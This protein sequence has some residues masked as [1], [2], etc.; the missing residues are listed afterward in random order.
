MDQL[1][2]ET[3]KIIIDEE[4]NEY[5]IPERKILTAYQ[6]HLKKLEIITLGIYPIETTREIVLSHR[7]LKEIPHFISFYKK[8]ETLIIINNE[9][10]ELNIDHLPV[11]LKSI[12]ISSNKIKHIPP[13]ISLLRNLSI[14][15]CNDNFVYGKVEHLPPSLTIL[16]LSKNRINEINCNL[17]NLEVLDCRYNL[18]GELPKINVNKIRILRCS[19]NMIHTLPLKMSKITQLVVYDNLIQSIPNYSS[20]HISNYNIKIGDNPLYQICDIQTCDTTI[21]NMEVFMNSICNEISLPNIYK[22]PGWRIMNP[23]ILINGINRFRKIYYGSKYGWRFLKYI[24]KKRREK[25]KREL[26]EKSA[27]MLL[28]PA[29][30]FA[31]LE[32]GEIDLENIDCIL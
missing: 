7:G 30:I 27:Q 2:R 32:M 18:I 28:N 22:I 13:T 1:T 25:I 5:K 6:K 26:M 31:M 9:I 12:N 16:H 15:V 14:F 4:K 24:L 19:H 20:L 21:N 11:S 29:R 8:L 3:N 17:P 23:K 10:E